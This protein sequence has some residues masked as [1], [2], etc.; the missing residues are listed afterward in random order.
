M[1]K[2]SFEGRSPKLRPVGE[3][4]RWVFAC[5]LI[6]FNS[7]FAWAGEIALTFDDAPTPDSDVMDGEA[8]TT[9][10]ISQLSDAG[11]K[12]ALFFVTTKHIDSTSEKRLR[13]YVK[14]GHLLGNHSHEHLSA[15]KESVNDI[16]VDAYRAHLILKP[17]DGVLPLYRFP[18]LHYGTDPQTREQISAGLDELGYSI[19]YVTVDNFDWYIDS[20]F[21]ESVKAGKKINKEKLGQLY[22][23]TIWE[24]I[25][26]YD[27]IAK[28]H[29]GRSPKHVLLLH[30]NDLAATYVGD[31]VRHIRSKGWKIISPQ[32]AFSDPISQ[33]QGDLAFTKQ[34]RVA[35]LAHESGIATEELRHPSESIEYLNE[36][37]EQYGVV[38]TEAQEAPIK[39]AP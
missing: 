21:R 25:E 15:N 13:D 39:D 36:M 30:E 26:F 6:A 9:K 7:H 28:K 20:L 5:L 33:H 19:G 10:L 1:V 14:A 18:Y 23:E 4:K 24:T 27:E 17:Y 38:E 29:L 2:V 8:R 31:L 12:Q 3:V 34:G 22:V 32:E 11:V 16:L 37:F 35:A